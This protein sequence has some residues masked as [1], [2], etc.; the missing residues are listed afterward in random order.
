MKPFSVSLLS[1]FL[2]KVSHINVFL[3]FASL[4]YPSVSSAASWSLG[5][6]A[7]LNDYGYVD[8]DAKTQGLPTVNYEQGNFYIHS[9]AAGY[10]LLN[11]PKDQIS[12]ITYYSPLGFDPDDS[13]NSQMKSLDKRDGTLMAGMAVTH[14]ERWGVIRASLAGDTLDNSNGVVGDVAFL[15]PIKTGKLRIAPGMG[16][17]YNNG[18]QN[19]YYYGISQAEAKRSHFSAY[20][21]GESWSPYVELSAN[22]QF[23]DHWYATAL[24][25]AVRLSSE[26]TD[27]PM[28]D[29]DI[30]SQV[31][32]GG[33]YRF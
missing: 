20:S 14:K 26:I 33:G 25:R 15:Y 4:V 6:A 19:D 2:R 17:V 13:H 31:L 18:N 32:L 8:T 27:S 16:A 28:V 24:L 7:M 1:F 23:S 22:Y 30:S 11:T 21:A 29:K 3:I 9:L 5:A 12:V 10:Y